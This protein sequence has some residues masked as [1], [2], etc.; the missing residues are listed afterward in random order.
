M[1]S[2]LEQVNYK[3]A[4][5]CQGYCNGIE[6]N[7]SD[8][9]ALGKLTRQGRICL[10]ASVLCLHRAHVPLQVVRPSPL[11]YPKFRAYN[12]KEKKRSYRKNGTANEATDDSEHRTCRE[13]GVA[14][15][16]LAIIK[17]TSQKKPLRYEG[18]WAVIA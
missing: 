12:I 1:S 8:T 16:L 11:I 15:H 4:P 17:N 7:L 13:A 9:T 3:N 6:K 10:R 5:F 18:A 14:S 2:G